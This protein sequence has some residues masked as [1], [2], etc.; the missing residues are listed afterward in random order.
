MACPDFNE[1]E[2]FI[3]QFDQ[4]VKIDPKTDKPLRYNVWKTT[5]DQVKKL[6]GNLDTSVLPQKD[7][8]ARILRKIENALKRIRESAAQINKKGNN[9]LSIQNDIFNNKFN[10]EMSIALHEVMESIKGESDKARNLGIEVS[11]ISDVGVLP[12]LPLSR[13]A[14]SIGR[15]I[16]FQ[17]GFRFKRATNAD[18]AATI[19]ALYYDLGREA[20]RQLE[21]AK[22]LEVRNDI[23]TIFDYQNK[24]DLKKDFPKNDPTRSD[25]LSV[26]L[27]EKKMGIKPGTNESEYFLNRT[28]ADLTDTVLGVV[29]EK[30]RIVALIT[31]QSTVILPDTKPGKTDA[32]LAQW[33]DGIKEPDGKTSAARKAIYKNPLF[34]NK[35][36]HKF[37]QLLHKDTSN[38]GKSATKRINEI[39]GTRKNMIRSLFG[40]KRSDDYSID[41]KESITGQNLSKT[42]PLDDIVE[43]YD[44]LQVDGK[45]APLHMPMKI[46]PNGR[47]YYLNSVLNPHASKASRHMLTPGEYTIDTGT[48]DFDYFVHK[49]A[50]NLKHKDQ[51][52][53]PKTYS[54]EDVISGKELTSALKAYENFQNATDVINM[55]QAL[56]PLIKQFPGLD[57]V[58]LLTGLQAVQDVRNPV[59]GKITTEFAVSEDATASGGTLTM[60]QALGTNEKVTE[61]LQRIG[62]LHSGDTLVK[63]DLKDLYGLMSKAIKEFI[64]GTGTGLGADLGGPDITG[65]L[66]DTLNLLFDEGNDIREFSKDPT[67]VFVYQQGRNS[68]TDS[69]SRK[70]ADRIIDNLGDPKIR[71]YLGILMGDKK[72]E[73]MESSELNNIAKLYPDIVQQLKKSDLP[74]QMFDIMK[75]NLRDLYLSELL[76]RSE[77]VYEFLKKLPA[78]TKFKILPAG[79]VMDGKKASNTGDLE[80]FGMPITTVVEVLNTFEGK[81][82]TVLTRENKLHKPVMDVSTIH[83]ID[84]ALLYHSIADVNPD[85]GIVVIHDEVRG[86]VKTI[87]AMETA[88]IKMTEKLIAQYD[89]HQQIMEAIASHSPEIAESEKFKALKKKID[90]NVAE[91]KIIISALFNEN[92]DALIGEGTAFE[93]FAKPVE[94]D[95]ETDNTVQS[96]TLNQGPAV[97]QD[98]GSHHIDI[99]DEDGTTHEVLAQEYWNSLQSRLDMVKKLKICL[100]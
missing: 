87:R 80:T 59:N 17:K 49:V 32:E 79:A 62:M 11:T 89:I 26:S 70:L 64:A 67:M 95:T 77:E 99:V 10:I 34:V 21:I 98:F 16:A 97:E 38:T 57:Y 69:I 40:L 93:T 55:M 44:L 68:A 83:A 4:S 74:Q 90:G 46:G 56:G 25:I 51:E 15:K 84:A 78:D 6:T 36:I 27:N 42:T 54:Y 53:N 63:Q 37:M 60:T 30:L 73:N 58:T 35:A 41:K 72:Y 19:E 7:E 43:M 5:M 1:F 91:K 20:I 22:Y 14:A 2:Q 85:S 31:Q 88:Y 47:L 3:V 48:A 66:N 82:D 29:T 39:F 81:E 92:T 8:S 45:P 94:V 65:I 76:T 13:V 61:F 12:A 50:K 18:S 33:D 28:E 96:T 9:N 100:K 71:E 52:G 75:D 24:E 23:P 86:N